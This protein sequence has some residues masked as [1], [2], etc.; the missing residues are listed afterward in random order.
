MAKQRIIEIDIA[1]GIAI[2]LVVIGHMANEKSTNNAA[3]YFI[4]KDAIYMFHM[5]L[6]MFLS[7]FI[8]YLTFSPFQSLI[9]YKQYIKKKFFR[10]MPA[11]FF[12]GMLIFI[13][14]TIGS[15]FMQIDHPISHYAE[16]F[17]II[18]IPHHSYNGALWYIYVLFEY[19]LI[20]PVLLYL[21]KQKVE[22]LLIPALVL[23][24]VKFPAYFASDMFFE[25]LFMFLLGC[26]I[27]K[28]YEIVSPFIKQFG[29][30]FLIIFPFL[31]FA[32]IES[33]NWPDRLSKLVI[34]LF[35]V[36]TVLY[37][38]YFLSKYKNPFIIFGTYTFAIYLMNTMII[39]LIKGLIFKFTP[40]SYTEFHYIMPFILLSALYFPIFIK[41]YIFDKLPLLNKLM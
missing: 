16:A 26:T 8:M 24:F 30:I 32:Y 10:L 20:V 29:W 3:W 12:F 21:A 9:E 41:K 2:M 11:F 36:P 39:G 34:G 1:T 25:F 31:L 13:G 27:A 6:F 17:K 22:L 33:T 7:G 35:S 19:Y 18:Y 15:K 14:K 38:S 28:N 37:L 23:Y 4:L 40:W 5:P